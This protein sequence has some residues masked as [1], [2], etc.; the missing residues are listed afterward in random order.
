MESSNAGVVRSLRWQR[1]ITRA[2]RSTK[3]AV[4]IG[5]IMGVNGGQPTKGS[6]NIGDVMGVS[7]AA[8]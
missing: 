2:R 5:H 8:H 6:V 4:N 1:S 3:G 7:G